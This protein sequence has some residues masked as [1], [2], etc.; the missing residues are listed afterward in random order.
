[1]LALYWHNC[2]RL[3]TYSF[4]GCT[5]T[6]VGLVVLYI[7]VSHMDM[8]VFLAQ[9]LVVPAIMTVISYF[10]HRY[11][12]FGDRDVSGHSG[13]RFT[14]VRLGGMGFSKLSFFLLV[15]VLGMQYLVAMIIIIGTLAWPTYRLNRDWA[16]K[17]VHTHEAASRTEMA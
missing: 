12:T 14:A 4:Y 13:G 8:N 15:G 7:M 3:R 17:G 5:L 6:A 1:M 10:V 16:F 2:R 11:R 9:A